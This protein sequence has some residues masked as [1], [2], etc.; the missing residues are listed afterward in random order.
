[1]VKCKLT[2]E[3]SFF[4]ITCLQIPIGIGDKIPLVIFLLMSYAEYMEMTF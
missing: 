4:A 2:L 3:V 1:M